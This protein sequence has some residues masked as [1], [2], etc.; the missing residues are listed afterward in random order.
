MKKVTVCL[1]ATGRLPGEAEII[2]VLLLLLVH[3]VGE[4]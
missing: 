4:E 1:K 2:I 3:I